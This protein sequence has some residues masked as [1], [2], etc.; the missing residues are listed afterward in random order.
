MKKTQIASD[1][2]VGLTKVDPTFKVKEVERKDEGAIKVEKLV[3]LIQL[4]TQN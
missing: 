4:M 1:Y 2:L 3:V